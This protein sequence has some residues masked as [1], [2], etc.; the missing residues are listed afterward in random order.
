[1]YKLL[2]FFILQNTFWKSLLQLKR[3]YLAIAVD[4]IT[5]EMHPDT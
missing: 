3:K 4:G 1:M 5:K 2:T